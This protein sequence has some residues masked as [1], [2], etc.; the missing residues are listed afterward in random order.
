MLRQLDDKTLVS[1]QIAPDDVAALAAQGVTMIVNNRPDDEDA[2]PAAR[3]RDRGRGARR[4]GSPIATSR[5]R[6]GSGPADVEAMREAMRRDCGDGQ[7]AGLLPLGHALGAGLRRWPRSREARR[8][9]ARTKSKRQA[10][11]RA[12]GVDLGRA[13]AASCF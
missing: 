10:A 7:D 13:I 12:P 11:L 8:R 6:A 9:I 2:G 1:G 3:R 5:S 4:R